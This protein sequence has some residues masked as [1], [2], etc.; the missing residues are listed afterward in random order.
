VGADQL[1]WSHLIPGGVVDP[2][3]SAGIAVTPSVIPTP[4]MMIPRL[5]C[6]LTVAK[7]ILPTM[8]TSFGRSSGGIGRVDHPCQFSYRH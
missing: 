6:R 4:A 5:K 8:L 3:A 2:A 1:D 7:A